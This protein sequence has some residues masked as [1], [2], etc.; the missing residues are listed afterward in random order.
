MVKRLRRSPLKAESWVR[1]PYGSPTKRKHSTWSAFFVLLVT[2]TL[3]DSSSKCNRILNWVRIF[4][5]DRCQLASIRSGE[6]SSQSEPSCLLLQRKSTGHLLL[7]K[8]SVTDLYQDKH[9]PQ[10]QKVSLWSI[11]VENGKYPH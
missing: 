2:R 10:T 9:T 7:F 5:Q 11:G 4:D 8:A 3:I 6:N 1:F